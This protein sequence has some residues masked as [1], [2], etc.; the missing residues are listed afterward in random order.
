M[1]EKIKRTVSAFLRIISVMIGIFL[2]LT[3]PDVK[4]QEGTEAINEEASVVS[5]DT[6]TVYND[7]AHNGHFFYYKDGIP[8]TVYCYHHERL[9]PSMNGT[10][11]YRRYDY[12]SSVVEDPSYPVTKEMMA[13][14]LYL[15]YPANATSL[16]E[17]WNCRVSSHSRGSGSCVGNRKRRQD[18]LV[19]ELFL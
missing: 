5:N 4:A 1:K 6:I 11:G 10:A 13:T 16:M 15:G 8:I 9:Q 12:F 18:R 7:P 2:L 19:T 17:H 3:A 14:I